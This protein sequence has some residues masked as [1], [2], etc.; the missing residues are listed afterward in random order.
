MPGPFHK[1]VCL[2][3]LV[4]LNLA[5]NFSA[6]AQTGQSNEA[7]GLAKKLTELRQ[8]NKYTEA[9]PVARHILDLVE[10]A[11]GPSHTKTAF[12]V[13]DLATLY[14]I[15][16]DYPR[17]EPLFQRSLRICELAFGPEHPNTATSLNNLARL[18]VAMSD[19]AKAEPLYRRSVQ[20]NE[21]ALGPEH[22]N[23]AT[24]LNNLATLYFKLSDYPKAEPL[25]Q[26]NLKIRE[27]VLGP[28]HPLTA[29][30]V[31]NLALLYETMGDYAK[32]EPLYQRGLKVNTKVLGRQHPD[33]ATSL[34]NLGLIYIKLG[35]FSKAEPLLR[36]G[37]AICEKAFGEDHPDT[38]TSL[39][40]LAVLHRNTASLAKAE[41]LLQRCLKISEKLQGTNH[42]DTATSLN[43][44]A[45]LYSDMGN[46]AQAEPL[47]QR[48]LK[49][50]ENV[51]GPNHPEAAAILGN[52]ALLEL[53]R[54]R[55]D[56]ALGYA[57]QQQATSL[58][59]SLGAAPELAQIVLRNKGLVL[60]SL[61]EERLAVEA[62]VDPSIKAVVEL[63]HA[64]GRQLMQ[65]HLEYPPDA[66]ADALKKWKTEADAMGLLVE[67]SQRTLTRKVM[68]TGTIRRALQ[69]KLQDVQSVLPGGTVLMEFVRY[70]H[71]LGRMPSEPR[72]GV[73]LIGGLQTAFKDEKPG[74][75]VWV[76]LGSAT[77]LESQLEACSTAMRTERKSDEAILRALALQL[78]A[79]VQKRLPEGCRS[80][81][82]CPDSQ[83]NFLNFGT[84]VTEGGE[85]L[86][87]HYSIKYVTSGR[88][89]VFGTADAPDERAIVAFANPA[90]SL[91]SATTGN[92][93][94]S[95]P[96]VALSSEHRGYDGLALHALPGTE[97]EIQFLKNRAHDWK[98]L[99]KEFVG[100]M[101]T[102]AEL[103][104]VR[105]PFILH[106]ATHGFFLPE[107]AT[108]GG[109]KINPRMA[110]AR[111]SVV[112]MNPMQRSG[113]ALAGA[114]NTLDAWKQGLVPP[115]ENDGILS[116][117]EVGSLNLRNTWLVVLSACDTGIG[118]ARNGEGVLGL[119][120]GFVQA[121]AQNL[122]MTLWPISDKWSVEIMKAFYEK[123][124]ASG[125]AP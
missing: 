97:Q 57:K 117:Q 80:L 17:A 72:Y 1:P 61:L 30:S 82:V 91:P 31:N 118:E 13:N 115:S 34:N 4:L 92:R 12:A 121:G 58:L 18:H 23:T 51:G 37:L 119:R 65:H 42:P 87:E 111:A 94:E 64:R 15:I 8:Q 59:A 21:K 78:F 86:A 109:R 67:E 71:H 63:L 16:G 73:L 96:L 95:T 10:K 20:I 22:P 28:E 50:Y 33:T 84:L 35:D 38:A 77:N 70:A 14:Q 19:Y 81:V 88:D 9:V 124:M 32:A 36:E 120:R 89:L 103:N 83:L 40:N 100:N 68:G 114:K 54:N 74:L 105:S 2:T 11:N 26:R 45:L 76:P 110:G 47:F 55:P 85:F 79:P 3:L 93:A 99:Q 98:L 53:D 46:Y 41:S 6:W 56:A 29:A 49:V 101:A 7:E 39:N 104:A 102:E 27:K 24:S 43:N 113:L 62:C 90:F 75:P 44:L 52:L 122:L 48:S 5:A 123:A 112:F 25:F 116:A 106:L 69:L 108:E 107:T 60:D 66:D 125:D